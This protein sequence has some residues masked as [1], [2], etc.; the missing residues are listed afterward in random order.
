M[1]NSIESRNFIVDGTWDTLVE[2]V[3]TD[4]LDQGQENLAVSLADALIRIH[5]LIDS[6]L[7]CELLEKQGDSN[8][9]QWVGRSGYHAFSY[10][11][12]L[13]DAMRKILSNI[14]R[15]ILD[16]VQ[17]KNSILSTIF[18]CL[19]E[20]YISNKH[21]LNNDESYIYALCYEIRHNADNELFTIDGLLEYND[22][23]IYK[24]GNTAA[25]YDR[26]LPYKKYTLQDINLNIST[27]VKY[28]LLK[29]EGNHYRIVF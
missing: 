26:Y 19:I 28:G 27:L 20:I 8:Y 10:T 17:K 13:R 21:L 25:N 6:S 16:F 2:C 29:A 4:I 3:K 5:E 23:V 14:P 9:V 24:I 7:K 1:S 12:A 11:N 15:F 18:Q 22:N